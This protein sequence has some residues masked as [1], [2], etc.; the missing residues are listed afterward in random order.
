MSNIALLSVIYQLSD[1]SGQ[2]MFVLCNVPPG[3]VTQLAVH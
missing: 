3:H 1:I 2:V